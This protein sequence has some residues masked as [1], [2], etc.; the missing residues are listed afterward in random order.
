MCLWSFRHQRRLLLIYLFNTFKELKNSY[1]YKGSA[2]DYYSTWLGINERGSLGN[3]L[4]FMS[5]GPYPTDTKPR[6]IIVGDYLQDSSWPSVETFMQKLSDEKHLYKPF[7]YVQVEMSNITGE[8]SLYY[9]NNNS[10]STYEKMNKNSRRF[11]FSISNSDPERPFKKVVN[12]EKVFIDII[13][14]YSLTNNKEHFIDS[15]IALLQNKSSNMPDEILAQF[16]RKNLTNP[17]DESVVDG[18]SKIKANYTGYWAN[19]FTRTSTLIL[20]DYDDNVEYYE[21]N[22]TKTSRNDT[23][24][25]WQMNSFNFQLKPFYTSYTTDPS[26]TGSRHILLFLYLSTLFFLIFTIFSLDLFMM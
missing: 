9:V 25:N 4:F 23:T 13:D 20:V 18:V 22:L 24:E 1:L 16:M 21:Y 7:N 14:R 15:M 11:I 2:P 5:Q 8:Y 26:Y 19:G 3:L 10:T 17:R 12:G 6:G